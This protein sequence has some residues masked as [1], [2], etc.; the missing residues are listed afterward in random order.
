M[1][2]FTSIAGVVAA[3]VTALATVFLWI[4]T[5]TLVSETRRMVEAGSSP[6][7]VATIEPNRWSMMHADIRVTNSGTGTAYDIDIA[8]DPPLKAEGKDRAPL[9]HI[10]VLRPGQTL[11]SFLSGIGP[12]MDV[13][14]TV[15]VTWR[16]T[17]KPS[18]PRETNEYTISLSDLKG[19]ELLGPS[20]PIM[21]VAEEMK[22]LREDWKNIASGFRRLRVETFTAHDREREQE[23]SVRL[24]EER[25]AARK[26]QREANKPN[27]A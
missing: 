1:E 6:H 27:D 24:A 9:A 15:T 14:H 8:F 25:Q 17:A 5:R 7:V 16:R 13:V 10:S 21:Q 23:E 12:L 4:A 26:A 20:E 19:F 18:A 2:F 22:H 11:A 3:G